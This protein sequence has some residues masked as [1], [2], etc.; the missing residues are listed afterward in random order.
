MSEELDKPQG[1]GMNPTDADSQDKANETGTQDAE[2][3]A[4]EVEELRRSNAQLKAYAKKLKGKSE[5]ADLDTPE[6]PASMDVDERILKSQ[7][8]SDELL[9]QLKKVAKF[10]EVD[11][12]TAQKDPMF[13]AIREKYEQEQRDKEASL[14]ASKGAGGLKP[15]KDF[16]TSGL[17]PEEH[18]AMW[19]KANKL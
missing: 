13:V 11:L 14:G 16:R 10:N 17:T 6:A 9:T 1:Q 5:R 7:G 15:Q 2:A 3:L 19:K 18:K 12:I 8:F 4:I